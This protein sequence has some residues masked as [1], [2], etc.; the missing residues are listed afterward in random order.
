VGLVKLDWPFTLVKFGF[1]NGFRNG[2]KIGPMLLKHFGD[3]AQGCNV[4]GGKVKKLN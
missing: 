4:K 2:K 3:K 1:K